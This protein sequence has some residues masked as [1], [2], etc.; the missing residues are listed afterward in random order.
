MKVLMNKHQKVNIFNIQD[1]DD[2]LDLNLDEMDLY[3]SFPG[4]LLP[5]GKLN[6]GLS[7][8]EETSKIEPENTI[9]TSLAEDWKADGRCSKCGKLAIISHF[10]LI[11]PEHG[12]YE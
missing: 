11:C 1:D 2:D 6:K 8:S 3:G 9:P 5:K 4:Y 12:V 7:G 10:Q